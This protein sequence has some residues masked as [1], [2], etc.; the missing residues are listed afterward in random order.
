[1]ATSELEP[2]ERGADQHGGPRLHGGDG[3][4]VGGELVERVAAAVARGGPV[5]L[6]VAA[7]VDGGGPPALVA[8]QAGRAAPGVAGLAAAVEQ[9]DGRP[10][11]GTVGVGGEREPVAGESE[12]GAGGG[13]HHGSLPSASRAVTLSSSTAAVDRARPYAR[14]PW[15]T[16]PGGAAEQAAF[17]A[18]HLA[19]RAGGVRA[20]REGDVVV[21]VGAGARPRR[22]RAADAAVVGPAAPSGRGSGLRGVVRA[23]TTRWAP[24]V[25]RPAGAPTA[26]WVRRRRAGAGDGPRPGR[27]RRRAGGRDPGR[28]DHPGRAPRRAGRRRPVLDRDRPAV[29][30][31]HDLPVSFGRHG[32]RTDGNLW[33]EA[34]PGQTAAAAGSSVR[35]KPG[36]GRGRRWTMTSS[37]RP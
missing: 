4:H 2:A 32:D 6:A 30:P 31:F 29:S 21:G 25:P 9:Q 12:R 22:D 23:P 37:T 36:T 11:G 5:A 17:T 8:E 18:D 15:T 14:P 26:A 34:L 20:P 16:R 10:V 13:V 3:T 1:M 7:Q 27:A 33:M 35:T 28:H 19:R 24:A